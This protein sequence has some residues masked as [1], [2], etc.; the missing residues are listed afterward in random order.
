MTK[1]Y[2]HS[3]R[4]TIGILIGK[5]NFSEESNLMLVGH[6]TATCQM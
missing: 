4:K 3:I 6:V 2:V 1:E 5:N